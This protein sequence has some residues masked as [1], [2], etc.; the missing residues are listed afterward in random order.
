MG[1]VLFDGK[2]FN[3]TRRW[4][5]ASA[6]RLRRRMGHARICRQCGSKL[7]PQ[8]QKEK[9]ER[10]AFGLFSLSLLSGIALNKL[11][12]ARRK[13]FGCIAYAALAHW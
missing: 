7:H 12:Q 2:N 5:K 3:R 13:A 9:P 6:W 11:H 8:R 10:G 4:A 1:Q